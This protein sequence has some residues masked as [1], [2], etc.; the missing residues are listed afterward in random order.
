M[1]GKLYHNCPNAGNPY[2]EC[3]DRCFERI[4]SRG[5]PKKEKKSFG[6][7]KPAWRKESHPISPVRVVAENR[8]PLLSYYAKKMVAS[9][10][11]SCSSS[12]DTFNVNLSRPP[13]PLHGNKSESVINWLP[14]S[15]SLAV[16][17]KKDS[18]ASNVSIYSLSLC[19]HSSLF[20]VYLFGESLMFP[21]CSLITVR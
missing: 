6:F 21:L 17:C 18:F 14:M 11:P 4:N 5:V 19:Y 7:G 12:D 13:S 16:Y 8:W 2:H 20:S 3:S 1:S 9:E 10:S 15:P